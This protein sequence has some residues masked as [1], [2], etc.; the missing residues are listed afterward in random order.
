M[1]TIVTGTDMMSAQATTGQFRYPVELAKHGATVIVVGR[2]TK[3]YFRDA[4]AEAKAASAPLKIMRVASQ[5]C[6]EFPSGGRIIFTGMEAGRG[7]HADIAYICG[8]WDQD[9]ATELA[10][11]FGNSKPRIGVI[12]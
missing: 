8:G 3:P 9:I 1:T 4:E 10:P 12:L 2:D 6:I 11:H 5:Q 7:I